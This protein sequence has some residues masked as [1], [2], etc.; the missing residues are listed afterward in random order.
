MYWAD[1]GV[2]LIFHSIL[3]YSILHPFSKTL[4]LCKV[5]EILEPIIL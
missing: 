3:F 4:V 5:A 2:L 1:M